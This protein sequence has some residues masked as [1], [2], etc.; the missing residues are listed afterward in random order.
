M[1]IS[2]RPAVV[3]S[4]PGGLL[5]Q[6][7]SARGQFQTVSVGLSWL[8]PPSGPVLVDGPKYAKARITPV[9]SQPWSGFYTGGHAGGAWGNSTSASYTDTANFGVQMFGSN[10][11]SHCWGVA[12]TG[13]GYA[14][15]I[16]GMMP[17][18]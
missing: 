17:T 3:A 7:A 2:E 4:S 10:V 8:F 5:N 13:L 14:I 16:C 9:V 1:W 6:S 12:T 11:T 15:S 18:M